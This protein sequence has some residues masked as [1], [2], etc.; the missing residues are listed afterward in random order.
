MD[1]ALLCENLHCHNG[2]DPVT[3]SR[4]SYLTLGGND[5]L[6]PP[7][8]ITFSRNKEGITMSPV[9]NLSVTGSPCPDT[10][11]QCAGDG[12]CLP[13]FLLCNAVYD[14]PGKE[15]EDRCDDPTCPGGLLIFLPS[16]KSRM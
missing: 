7:A 8:V 4:K 16:C 14:C 5:V 3:C 13:V 10:H 1:P 2:R 11:F 6:P 9:A 12:Y 15:D